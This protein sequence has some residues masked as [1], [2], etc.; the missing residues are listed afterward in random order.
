MTKLTH[1]WYVS[2]RPRK[3]PAKESHGRRIAESFPSQ[4]E[5]K[6]Y[7]RSKLAQGQHDIIAGTLN[8][9]LPKRTIAPSLVVQWLE[10]P[11]EPQS[12]VAE[13]AAN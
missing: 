4:A 13:K 5:A 10:E 1:T 7:T 6:N 2:F 12:H 11:E 9:H 3:P 8:P